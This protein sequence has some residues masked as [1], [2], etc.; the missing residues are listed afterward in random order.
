MNK[1]LK[2]G[3]IIPALNEE[4]TIGKV[5]REVKQTMRG[6]K[7][8]HNIFVIAD[9]STD[10]TVKIAKKLNVN[11]HGSPHR[12]GLA[13]A[14]KT[15]INEC[16]K[17]K[18][19]IVVLIDGDG[20]YRAHESP[21]LIT[22]ILKE[23]NDIVLGS[24]FL[25]K[26]EG[27]PLIKK[28]GNIFFSKVVS[29]IVGREITDAQTGFRAFT[30][31]F[32]ENIRIVADYTYTQEMI[33]ESVKNKF[34]LKEVP[35]H[36]GKREFGKSRL[37]S[38]PFEYAI[39]AGIDILRIYRDYEPLKFFGGIGLLLFLFGTLSSVY[40]F[41]KLFSFGLIIVEKMIPT[42]LLSIF[43]MLSGLQ[44]LMFGFLADKFRKSR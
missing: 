40:I 25:G 2:V 3:I 24:R 7:I 29:F 17:Y 34:K 28:I 21:N 43:L 14:L 42:L 16:L 6:L 5:I 35:I 9:G 41:T 39:K 1:K 15:G 32:A 36:F 38:N 10:D 26:I 33:I 11:V 20:K 30:K 13:E 18:A 27:M 12:H 8:K 4:K 44:I 37:M 23:G 19:N 31:K 22:P